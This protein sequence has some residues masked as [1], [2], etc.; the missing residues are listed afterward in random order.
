MDDKQFTVGFTQPPLSHQLKREGNRPWPLTGS[1]TVVFYM[2]SA[3]SDVPKVNGASASIADVTSSTVTYQ[4]QAGDVDT[5]GN[6]RG[7]FRVTSGT[8]VEETDEFDIF[9][10]THS[11]GR[12]ALIGAVARAARREIPV[13]WDALRSYDAY[14]DLELQE[15][16]EIVKLNVLGYVVAVADEANLD[17]RVL[18][19]LG[20]LVAIEVIP[21][22]IDY[23]TDQIVSQTARGSNEVQ[24]FPNRIQALERKLDFLQER[25]EAMYLQ[26]Q[27]LVG[28]PLRRLDTAPDVNTRGLPLVTPGLEDFPGP[29]GPRSPDPNIPSPRRLPIPAEW[30]FD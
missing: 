27:D 24:T 8:K 10:L 17:R 25:V 23:W 6:W 12:G 15:K 28:S 4:W 19:Y 22:A 3:L 5:G 14:G 1:E 7:W 20:K 16:V 9:G 11:P 18:D 29:Y 13:A 30:I 2:R 26:I 21:A